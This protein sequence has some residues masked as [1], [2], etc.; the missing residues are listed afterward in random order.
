VDV[1]WQEPPQIGILRERVQQY[2]EAG[3]QAQADCGCCCATGS[4]GR[5]RIASG[6]STAAARSRPTPTAT[7]TCGPASI[8][9][10]TVITFALTIQDILRDPEV[11]IGIFS[12]TRPIAK[13]FLR[14]IK[15]EFERNERLKRW[16]PDILWA[17][18]RKDSPKWSEDEGI[19]SSS[20]RATPRRRRS[21]RGAWSTASR[22]PSTSASW[23]TMTW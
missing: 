17:D 7:S 9:S 21:R 18:P 22:R 11:T 8:K 20:A 14:Q 4:G 13:A 15:Q 2:L 12:H 1:T 5:T 23:F 6:C 19:T 16:F 3:K 10:S